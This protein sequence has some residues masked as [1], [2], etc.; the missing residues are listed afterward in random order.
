MTTLIAVETTTCGRCGGLIEWVPDLDDNEEPVP[1]GYGLWVSVTTGL[2]ACEPTADDEDTWHHPDP[3]EDTDAR[4]SDAHDAHELRGQVEWS[5]AHGHR[6]T[7]DLD[8]AKAYARTRRVSTERPATSHDGDRCVE[9]LLC[10]DPAGTWDHAREWG[11]GETSE[12]AWRYALG[13]LLAG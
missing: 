6:F 9:V 13:S 8:T 3:V 5:A 2:E 10:T 4:T 7:G 1:E 11:R 12:E